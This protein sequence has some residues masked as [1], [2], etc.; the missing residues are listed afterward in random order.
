MA[1]IFAVSL[2]QENFTTINAPQRVRLGRAS[3]ELKAPQVDTDRVRQAKD[4]C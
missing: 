2:Y 3:R 4:S 1:A